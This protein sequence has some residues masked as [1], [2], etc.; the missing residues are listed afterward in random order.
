M[1]LFLMLGITVKETMGS[2]YS[3]TVCEVNKEKKMNHEI[4]L[5]IKLINGSFGYIKFI[6]M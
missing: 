1:K 3:S 2:A 4:T 5:G 6:F